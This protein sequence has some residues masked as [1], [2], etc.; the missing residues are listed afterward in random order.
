M[1]NRRIFK[2]IMFIPSS[3]FMSFFSKPETSFTLR[4][5]RS[6]SPS[7]F[8]LLT[9][10]LCH[11]LI[12]R[13]FFSSFT[14]NINNKSLFTKFF[15]LRGAR[16][17]TKLNWNTLINLRLLFLCNCVVRKKEIKEFREHEVF[18]FSSEKRRKSEEEKFIFSYFFTLRS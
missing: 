17:S 12:S 16:F 7:K 15:T 9:H 13:Q 10:K 14:K 4:Y 11:L 6:F 5:F 8:L 2:H 1:Q 18:C 3:S